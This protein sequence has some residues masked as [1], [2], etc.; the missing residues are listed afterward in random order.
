MEKRVMPVQNGVE[1]VFHPSYVIL[2]YPRVQIA[3]EVVIEEAHGRKLILRQAVATVR[4]YG[5]A[6]L[7]AQFLVRLAIPL[8]NLI[9]RTTYD[10]H[11]S[12]FQYFW[13]RRF[14]GI[15]V[16]LCKL[17]DIVMPM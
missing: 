7:L 16:G 4:T 1:T 2:V 6:T 9:L 8:A 12:H 13:E 11:T 10:A 14:A 3:D 5:Y 17:Y 15:H